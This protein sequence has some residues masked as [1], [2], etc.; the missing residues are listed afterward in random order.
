[1]YQLDILT[2]KENSFSLCSLNHTTFSQLP[3]YI[4]MHYKKIPAQASLNRRKLL[5]QIILEKMRFSKFVSLLLLFCMS[6][7][8]NFPEIKK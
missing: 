4:L 1:M 5:I 6:T 8:E 3:L 7:K 2:V